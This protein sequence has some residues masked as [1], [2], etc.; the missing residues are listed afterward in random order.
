[1]FKTIKTIYLFTYLL[2]T[3]YSN[4]TNESQFLTISELKPSHDTFI[5]KDN[6]TKQHGSLSKI[7]VT[8]Q[9]SNQRIGLIK[10]DTSGVDKNMLENDDIK[11][12]LRLGVAEI[13]AGGPVEI[14][15]HRLENEFDEEDTS[16]ENFGG[17]SSMH[18]V[19]NFT[20]EKKHENRLGL[21]DISNLIVPGEDTV[22]AF[23][24]G[25]RGHVKF[26][27]KEQN[28]VENMSPLLIVQKED[29]RT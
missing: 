22:L 9:G 26:H 25:Q 8:Q 12:Y 21:V 23:V 16:W 27:S 11:V 19:V 1:M 5:R 18:T 7:A 20:V 6:I 14:K 17:A 4:N 3:A 28:S 15:V 24:I 29:R 13:Y 2:A 10:F